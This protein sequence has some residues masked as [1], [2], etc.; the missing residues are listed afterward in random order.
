MSATVRGTQRRLTSVSVRVCVCVAHFVHLIKLSQVDLCCCCCCWCRAQQGKMRTK[1]KRKWPIVLS[2]CLIAPLATAA[3]QIVR[4]DTRL[5]MISDALAVQIIIHR[6][7]VRQQREATR[8]KAHTEGST[9]W[10]THS[11]IQSGWRD[12]LDTE[13][14][15]T[16][17]VCPCESLSKGKSQGASANTNNRLALRLLVRIV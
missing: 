1:Q 13:S 3:A 5:P 7:Y 15:G 14:I 2:V 8:N 12:E 6:E 4:F 10:P 17:L 16:N 11:L 9:S